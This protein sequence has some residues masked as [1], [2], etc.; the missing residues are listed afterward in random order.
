MSLRRL[1][2]LLEELHDMHWDIVVLTET[3]RSDICEELPL[4]GGHIFYG[5][6]GVKGRCG[7]GFLVHDRHKNCKFKHINERVAFIDFKFKSQSVR[8]FGV[9][10]PHS[11][12]PDEEVETVYEILQEKLHAARRK[13][14]SC[15]VAG[16]M[17]AQV[18][19]FQEHDDPANLGPHG[20]ETYEGIGCCGGVQ[21]MH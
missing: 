20:S 2:S 9:Y 14:F 18:G 6:G 11:Q 8:I 7:V 15:I 12:H 13:S 1:Y 21:L 5:S 4:E 16:D 3:W 17:N 10:M 19:G